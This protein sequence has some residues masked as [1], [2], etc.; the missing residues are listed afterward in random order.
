MAVDL[1]ECKRQMGK[2][3]DNGKKNIKINKTCSKCYSKCFGK[4]FPFALTFVSKVLFLFLA[5]GTFSLFCSTYF[6]HPYDQLD[7]FYTK[8][9][10]CHVNEKR[11]KELYL[12]L[13]K[14]TRTLSLAPCVESSKPFNTNQKVYQRKTFESLSKV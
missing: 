13:I 3:V 9:F 12:N 5:K 2:F 8:L 6:S 10:G 1:K 7:H 11:K 14:D 4:L